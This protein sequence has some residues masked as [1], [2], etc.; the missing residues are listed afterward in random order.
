MRC[1]PSL[2]CHCFARD[3]LPPGCRG[4]R[5]ES[6]YFIAEA[7]EKYLLLC[8]IEDNNRAVNDRGLK[9]LDLCLELSG[10]E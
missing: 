9:G 10:Y 7:M 1:K 2:L 8:P 3:T 4:I 6:D 5:A